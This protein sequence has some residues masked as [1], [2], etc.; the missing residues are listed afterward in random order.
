MILRVSKGLLDLHTFGVL[1]HDIGS[2]S[3]RKR[4]REE[5][6][7]EGRLTELALFLASRRWTLRP[8]PP[9]FP[10]EHEAARDPLLHE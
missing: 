2:I 1:P 7:I 6:R 8:G 10:N 3:V 4:R 5:P 9:S